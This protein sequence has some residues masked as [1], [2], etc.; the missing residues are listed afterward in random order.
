MSE[1][2]NVASI[3]NAKNTSQIFDIIKEYE[4]HVTHNEP[5]GVD[6]ELFYF[7]EQIR[8]E[9]YPS[10]VSQRLA[11]STLDSYARR[12]LI[13]NANFFFNNGGLK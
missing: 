11:F 8:D 2:R 6:S 7:I 9:G 10:N 13:L 5:I 1:I 4:K 3:L 12:F